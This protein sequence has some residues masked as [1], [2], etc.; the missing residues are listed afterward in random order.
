[1]SVISR[2]LNRADVCGVRFNIF[3]TKNIKH[4][5]SPINGKVIKITHC[6]MFVED[7][8]I[9]IYRPLVH[10]G[11]VVKKGQVIGY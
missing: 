6:S 9:K 5:K 3:G 8:E 4:I 10:V 2:I 11:A 7:I 1:M